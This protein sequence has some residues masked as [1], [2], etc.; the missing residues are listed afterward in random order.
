[1]QQ[2]YYIYY[3]ARIIDAAVQSC[4]AQWLTCWVVWQASVAG[5]QELTSAAHALLAKRSWS[6]LEDRFNPFYSKC[7]VDARLVCADQ[8]VNQNQ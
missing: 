5:R 2:A 1:M 4:M 6:G 8:Q 7:Q 3:V